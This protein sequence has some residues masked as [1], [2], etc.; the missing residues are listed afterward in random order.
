MKSVRV[1]LI[2]A[3]VLGWQAPG[4]EKPAGAQATQAK[5]AETKF[6]ELKYLKGGRLERVIH[7][8]NGLTS[9][10]A[11]IFFDDQLNA[12]AIKGKPEDIASTEALLRRFDVPMPESRTRQIQLT[13]YMIEATNQP[14]QDSPLPSSLMSALEQLEAAFGYKSLRLMDTILLQGREG[15]PVSLSGL[16]PLTATRSGE[17]LFYSAKYDHAGYV[18]S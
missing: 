16:L 6:V 2:L 7:L 17:K 11:Q 12:L 3:L 4:Q 8:V 15:A 13:I 5:S 18:E 1:V 10:R 14:G 9:M